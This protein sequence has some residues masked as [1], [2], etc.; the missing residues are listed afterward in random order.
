MKDKKEV[1]DKKEDK[2][3]DLN[4]YPVKVDKKR[5]NEGVS[6]YPLSNSTHLHLICGRVKAG[7]S[8]LLN[9]LYMSKRFFAKD[10]KVKI[11]IST[12][13][14]NDAV[15]KYMIEE[16]D[17]VFDTYSDAL[18]DE[19]LHMIETDEETGKYLI[20]FDDIIGSINFKRTGKVDKIS[21][22]VSHYRHIGNE[23]Q[24]GRIAIAIASQYFK[25]FN[26]I[27]RTNCSGYYILGEFPE[28]EVKKMAEDLSYFGGGKKEF[29]EVFKKSRKEPHDFLYLSVE[30]LEAR[31][32]HTDLLWSKD[33]GI[34]GESG[35]DAKSDEDLDKTQN[36]E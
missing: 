25:Y 7:K 17:F 1:K 27:L 10:F 2:E 14:H 9:S 26:G 3:I 5:L 16:F 32:N 6:K 35:E 11:L 36:E 18:M 22:L 28:S 4:I 19:I 24:E 20:I 23:K 34:I 12:T 8:T 30:H 15:N 33:K 21:E 13:A 29:M 31:R